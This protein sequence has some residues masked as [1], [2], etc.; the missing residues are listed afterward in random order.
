MKRP[1]LIALDMDGTM[2]DAQSRLT[3]RT[4]KALQ[5]AQLAGIRV[6]AA[7]GR[8]YPSAMIHI[9]DIGIE[10]ASIFYNGA[11]IRDPLTDATIFERSLGA[12]L[13]AEIL[14]FFKENDWYVQI[15]SQDKLIVRDRDD[16]RCKYYENICGLTAAALGEKFW[17]CG[18]DSSKLLGICFDKA[19]FRVMCETVRDKFG[20]RIYQATSW[21]AFIEMVHPDVNKAA[22][23]RRVA[24]Y[25][26]IS[27]ENVTAIGDGI[28][29]IEMIEW[30]GTGI[31]MGNAKDEVKAAA[32]LIAPSN[33]EE[34]AA[35]VVEEFL[36]A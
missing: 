23:L 34:G 4:K 26:G 32:D 13:T 8:M 18:L 36:K 29:D 35:R 5:N 10:S 22:A 14:S 31:A 28:N 17:N 33:E 16:E 21:G 24:E 19:G 11:L 1:Q 9:R 25:Y 20:A 27:R 15:Y 3:A 12:A 30:A 2:L 6:V 7:T